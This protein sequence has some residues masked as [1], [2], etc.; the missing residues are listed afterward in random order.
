[1]IIC[2]F[3]Y[4]L[5]ICIITHKTAEEEE[6]ERGGEGERKR[7]QY[8]EISV[9]CSCSL[10]HIIIIILLLVLHVLFFGYRCCIQN[11]WRTKR[12][13]EKEK[14]ERTKVENVFSFSKL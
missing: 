14:I 5:Y 10:P 6:V 1:M 8:K 13:R 3:T 11:E 2:L 9:H 12:E 4:P 7:A